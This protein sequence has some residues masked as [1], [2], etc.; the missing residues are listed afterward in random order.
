M[1]L[2]RPDPSTLPVHV[3]F[4]QEYEASK[5]EIIRDF[6]FFGSVIAGTAI[7]GALLSSVMFG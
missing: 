7:V 4:P 6:A 2:P 5:R 1:T 3:L